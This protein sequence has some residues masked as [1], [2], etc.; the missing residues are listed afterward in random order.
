[1][2]LFKIIYRRT[3]D[4]GAEEFNANILGTS[5]ERIR[6]YLTEQYG[7]LSYFRCEGRTEVH[8]IMPEV[9]KRISREDNGDNK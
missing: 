5:P 2:I 4:T 6:D 7:H 1:M 8:H 3:T 9:A